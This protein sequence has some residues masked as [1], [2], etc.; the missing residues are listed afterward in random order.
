[1]KT[2]TMIIVAA[3]ATGLTHAQEKSTTIRSTAS[4]LDVRDHKQ[5]DVEV[6]TTKLFR[7]KTSSAEQVYA[8]AFFSKESDSLRCFKAYYGTKEVFDRAYFIWEN[9]STVAIR[10]YNTRDKKNKAF[11]VFGRGNTTGIIDN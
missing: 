6:Y 7:E 10:L 2:L 3:L 11:R 8:I 1:M 9:D 5:S 4:S